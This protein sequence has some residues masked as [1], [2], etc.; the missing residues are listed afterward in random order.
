LTPFEMPSIT[1]MTIMSTTSQA[2]SGST[3]TSTTVVT[4]K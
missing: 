4:A 2:D 1:T 3:T